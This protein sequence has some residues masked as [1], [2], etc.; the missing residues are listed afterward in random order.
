MSDLL[1]ISYDLGFDASRLSPT[2][3]IVTGANPAAN[4]EVTFGTVPT[5]KYWKLVT[6]S[7]SCAQGATQTPLPALSITDGT[8]IIA[9]FPGATAAI[10][11]STTSRLTWAAGLRTITAGAALTANSAPL[12]DGLILPPGYVVATVTAGIGANT[13]FAAGS[14]LVVEY[15]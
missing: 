14:L 15:A 10:S 11:A 1:S 2:T 13:D 8:T 12:P 4:T 6:A 9:L 3:K 7:V 5:G